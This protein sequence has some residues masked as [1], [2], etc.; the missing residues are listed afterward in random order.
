MEMNY[1]EGTDL[2]DYLYQEYLDKIEQL[3]PGSALRHISQVSAE[4]D[5]SLRAVCT[6]PLASIPAT[7]RRI[8]AVIVCWRLV[9]EITTLM[10]TEASSGNEWIPLQTLY[11]QAVKDLEAIR[12]GKPGYGLDDKEPEAGGVDVLAPDRMFT[13]EMWSKF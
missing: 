1:C 6:L 10:D 4:I 8:C 5:D 3:S 13:E 7:V 9:G 2:N 11:K 12:E